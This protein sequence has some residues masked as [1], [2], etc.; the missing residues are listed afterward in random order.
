[1]AG[2]LERPE[3]ARL[4]AA[5][6]VTERRPS[7]SFLADGGTPRVSSGRAFLA[8]TELAAEDASAPRPRSWTITR[9]PNG[10][11]PDHPQP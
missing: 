4:G 5:W 6:D 11:C 1:M 10:F 3:E 7:R 9:R 2:R 8:A